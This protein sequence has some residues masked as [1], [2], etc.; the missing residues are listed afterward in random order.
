MRL[1][2]RRKQGVFAVR[3]AREPKLPSEKVRTI[4]TRTLALAL[5]LTLTLTRNR[6]PNPNPNPQAANYTYAPIVTPYLL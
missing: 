4:L 5:A 2:V 6:N 1:C 3:V